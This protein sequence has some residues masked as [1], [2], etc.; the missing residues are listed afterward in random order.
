LGVE[1]ELVPIGNEWDVEVTPLPDDMPWHNIQL[2]VRNKDEDDE[3][4]TAIK[5]LNKFD[6]IEMD[7]RQD[8]P[9]LSEE[10]KVLITAIEAVLSLR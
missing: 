4:D 3:R 5:Y 7:V 8:H 2:N 9:D 10:R 6:D 1:V